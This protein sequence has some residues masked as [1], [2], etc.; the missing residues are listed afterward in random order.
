MLFASKIRATAEAAGLNIRFARNMRA[1]M[2]AAG[3]LMPDLII[4]DL[5][6]A[7]LN[8][9]GLAQELKAN[10]SL[11]DICLLGFFSH[12]ETELRRQAIEAGFDQV[13]PR[14]VFSR[15]LEKILLGQQDSGRS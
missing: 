4:V 13:L 2:T 9:M 15:D 12:V 14:S 7:K 6:N 5:H 1:L 11:K 3:E 8:A 10:H